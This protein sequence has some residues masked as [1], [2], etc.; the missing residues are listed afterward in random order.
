MLC[1]MSVIY[2]TSYV[3]NIQYCCFYFGQSLFKTTKTRKTMMLAF[4]LIF[5]ISGSLNFFVCIQTATWGSF[6]LKNFFEHFFWQW[7]PSASVCLAMN[8][9]SFCL[10]GNESPSPLFVWKTISYLFLKDIFAGY[11]ILDWQGLGIL[12]LIFFLT[13]GTLKMLS[14]W[15]YHLCFSICNVSFHFGFLQHFPVYF[16]YFSKLVL[17]FL[18]LEV[19]GRG[20]FFKSCLGFLFYSQ[21]CLYFIVFVCFVFCFH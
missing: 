6:C 12:S 19:V 20:P 5:T 3:I 9:F 10:S 17:M 4:I 14:H 21:I 13:F 2:F 16:W 1:P 11:R 15:Y 18:K 7:I 8:P